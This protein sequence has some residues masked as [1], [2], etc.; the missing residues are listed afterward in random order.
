MSVG[1]SNNP[2]ISHFSGT[3]TPAQAA[4]RLAAQAAQTGQAPAGAP[5]AAPTD[6]PAGYTSGGGQAAYDAGNT[7]AKNAFNN[8]ASGNTNPGSAYSA[9]NPAPLSQPGAYEA[10]IK[11][12]AG[13]LSTPTNTENL[14]GSGASNILN[15]SPLSAL[16]SQNNNSG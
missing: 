10:W 9:A 15:N 11:A 4:A 13:S 2:G 16:S 3:E 6:Y 7:A 14:Y 1:Y 12:N 8:P 5:P